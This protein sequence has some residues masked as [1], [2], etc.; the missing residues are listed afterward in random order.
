MFSRECSLTEVMLRT[1]KV[2]K[3]LL[4]IRGLPEQ[5]VTMPTTN[6]I[7]L[8][9]RNSIGLIRLLSLEAYVTP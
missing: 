3:D 5:K 9:K 2:H 4:M 8:G 7:L 1:E 6:N